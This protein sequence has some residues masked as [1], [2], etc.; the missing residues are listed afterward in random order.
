MTKLLE[1]NLF[2]ACIVRSVGPI[3]YE[4]TGAKHRAMF[5]LLATAPF[6]RRT[7]SFLQDTLWGTS[8]FDSG[9]QS[10]RRALSDI[11]AL[12][13]PAYEQVLV[14]NNTEI[15]M[16]L[17]C[18]HFIGRPGGGEFLEGCIPSRPEK[19]GEQNHH[20]TVAQHLR[21]IQDGGANIGALV[22]WGEREEI[23]N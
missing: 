4:V 1:I 2:G 6:G 14:V 20:P 5:A 17:D 19:I 8:C 13:G 21:G 7:R 22:G 23:A 10:L 3:A 12:M 9:R 11:K 15:S 16:K 18:V